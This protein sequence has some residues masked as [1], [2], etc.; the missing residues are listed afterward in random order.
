MQRTEKGLSSTVHKVIFVVGTDSIDCRH[1]QHGIVAGA[2]S[3]CADR[4]AVKT[5]RGVTRLKPWRHVAAW[6]P[7]EV[8][9]REELTSQSSLGDRLYGLPYSL[10]LVGVIILLAESVGEAAVGE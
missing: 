10:I 9:L 7:Y 6:V 4:L 5:D 8:L 1:G 3:T 2:S